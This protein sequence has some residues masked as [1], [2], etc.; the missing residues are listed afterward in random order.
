MTSIKYYILSALLFIASSAFA[1]EADT[2]NIAAD[3]L[4][5]VV[6]E[7]VI[8][9]KPVRTRQGGSYRHTPHSQQRIEHR[10]LQ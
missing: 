1:Q 4:R 6:K 7:E 10:A 3:S 9:V 5:N 2:L 8:P